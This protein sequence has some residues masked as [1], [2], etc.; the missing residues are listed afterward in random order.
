MAQDEGSGYYRFPAIH[1][2]TLVFVSED[3]LWTVPASGGVARRL[4]SGLGTASNPVIS[5]TGDRIAFSGREEGPAEVFVMPF[6]GGPPRRVTFVGTAAMVVGWTPRGDIIYASDSG[7]PFLR[8]MRLFSVSPE[9]GLSSELP[10][11]P[12]VFISYG[13]SGGCVIARPSVEA[14]YWKRYRGGTTGDLWIDTTA[15][16]TGDAWSK[17]R[18]ILLARSGLVIAFT[19]SPITTASAISIHV[20]HLARTCDNTLTTKTSTSAGPVPTASTSSIT[21]GRTCSCS[22][23]ANTRA[24]K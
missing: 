10:T 9:S 21:P 8:M 11:G 7:Q 2:H 20:T 22:I 23:R 4:T 14:A 6:E 15:T 1:E 16:V 5:P 18:A 13:S 24:G 12:A 17:S 19:S 3:D